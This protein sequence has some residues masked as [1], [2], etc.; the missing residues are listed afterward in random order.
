M[1]WTSTRVLWMERFSM[2]ESRRCCSFAAKS[3]K[4]FDNVSV[5]LLVSCVQNSTDV[6][7]ASMSNCN[8]GKLL[9]KNPVVSPPLPRRFKVFF[10]T[11]FKDRGPALVP[12]NWNVC[13]SLVCYGSS[14]QSYILEDLNM[15]L[16]IQHWLDLH[17]IPLDFKRST[18]VNGNIERWRKLL[19]LMTSNLEHNHLDLTSGLCVLLLLVLVWLTIRAGL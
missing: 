18:F 5:C 9:V 15:D 16:F 10:L 11:D 17:L 12:A 3:C 4:S 8:S 2:N 1:Q 19:G 6:I 13:A 14:Q 7:V